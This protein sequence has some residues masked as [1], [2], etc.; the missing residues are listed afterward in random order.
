MTLTLQ[1]IEEILKAL[2]STTNQV[3]IDKVEAYRY[4]LT[5]P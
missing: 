3:L 1:E 2:Q 5:R 4:R